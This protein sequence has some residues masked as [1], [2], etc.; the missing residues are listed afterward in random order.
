MY[1]TAAWNT[2]QEPIASRELSPPPF[3]LYFYFKGEGVNLTALSQRIS[4]FLFCKQKEGS[5]A[6]KESHFN[7]LK[8]PLTAV[9]SL[10]S[11]GKLRKHFC[12]H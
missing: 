2:P 1:T 9:L 4:Q 7:S 6:K 5:Q 8:N 3:Y 10:P 12:V 11:R